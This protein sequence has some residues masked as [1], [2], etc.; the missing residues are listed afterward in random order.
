MNRGGAETLIMNI[1]REI[2]RD[3]YCFDFLLNDVQGDYSDEIIK[4]GGHIYSVPPRSKGFIAYCNALDKF[5][6]THKGEYQAVHMHTSSLS[7]LEFLYYAKCYGIKVRIIHSHNTAQAGL[8]HNVLHWLQK[9][10]VSHLATDYLACSEVAAKWL[11]SRTAVLKKSIVVNNGIDVER[12]SYN[13][14]YRTEIRQK[15]DI[16][17][18][19][20]VIGHVGRFDIVKNHK[21]LIT[22]FKEYHNLHPNSVL[23]LVGVG[24][25]KEETERMVKDM[26]MDSCVIFAGLQTEIYKYLSCFDYF[27]FPSLY[28]GLPVALVEAQ[29]SGVMTI[30]S[31]K[32]SPESKLSSVLSFYPLENKANEWASYI[33]S[34]KPL[35]RESSV[36]EIINSGYSIKDTVN[37]LT[38]NVYR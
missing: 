1:F 4:L 32:V 14:E 20:T 27:V 3:N 18:T 5:F 16:A 29:T 24:L 23:L 21:F 34:L 2:D 31:D 11:Y 33:D 9:P 22:I 12:F 13:E 10:F 36:T 30:C 38:S 7:S 25:L 17:T 8:M 15:H 28:E 6:R 35:S 26:G 37:Y 19:T